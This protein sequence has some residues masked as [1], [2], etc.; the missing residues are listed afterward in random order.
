MRPNICCF[1]DWVTA[2]IIAWVSPQR[3]HPANAH[4]QVKAVCA[5]GLCC[6]ELISV[7]RENV[8]TRPPPCAVNS[9]LSVVCEA[10]LV[11]LLGHTRAALWCHLKPKACSLWA[12]CKHRLHWP[13][14]P[15]PQ[16]QA[17]VKPPLR[18][19][20]SRHSAPLC[21]HVVFWHGA[22]CDTSHTQ[23]LV[24]LLLLRYEDAFRMA[25]P[26]SSTHPPH[27]TLHIAFVLRPW[28]EGQEG[29]WTEMSCL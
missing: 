24:N 20:A 17:G 28:E 1:P 19:N 21:A 2:F 25:V 6:C 13:T 10:C 18:R 22:Q 5:V 8:V 9:T 29:Q 12:D 23:L 26:A 3:Q 15:A 4:Y 27:I 11:F 7:I 16:Q 14:V